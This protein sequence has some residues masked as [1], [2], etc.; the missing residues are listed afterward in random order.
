M[1]QIGSV[2]RRR[3]AHLLKG[4]VPLRSRAAFRISIISGS[5]SNILLVLRY[6]IDLRKCGAGVGD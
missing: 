1:P 5:S 4:Y 3:V 2:A 6:A